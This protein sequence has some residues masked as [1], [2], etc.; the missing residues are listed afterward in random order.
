MTEPQPETPSAPNATGIRDL[1]TGSIPRHLIAFFWPMLAGNLL[2]SAHSLINAFWVGKFL[3][4]T[5][6]A[7]IMTSFPVVFV[8]IAVAG[9]L[10]MASNILVSQ[11]VGA[12]NLSQV[13]RVVQNSTILVIGLS[14]LFTILG[15]F[16]ALPLLRLTH[17]PPDVLPM[18]YDYLRVL[19]LTMPS[20]FAFFLFSSMLR[21]AGDSATP[22]RYMSISIILTVILDPIL[23]FG[24]LGLPRL[25][26]PGT[27]VANII[28]QFAAVIMLLMHLKRQGNIVMPQWQGLKLDWEISRQTFVLGGPSA[29]QQAIVSIGAVT[30]VGFI[31]RFGENAAAAFGAA[32]R[33]DQFAF[34]PAMSMGAAVA[35]LAGQNIGARRF[36]RVRQVFGWGV[37]ISCGLTL[38][39][40]LAAILIPGLL[41]RLFLN[42]T[43][44]I[45]IGVEYLRIIGVGYLFLAVYFTCIGVINGAGHTFIPTV[46]TVVGLWLI[47]I[48]L[49]ANLPAHVGGVRGIWYAMA[50]SFAVSMTLGL[51]Y[52]FSGYWRRAI[53]RTQS[54]PPPVPSPEPE[55]RGNIPLEPPPLDRIDPAD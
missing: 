18:A 1:T 21:G 42:D 51:I 15:E 31:N 50:I 5:A 7:A 47:R 33:I 30:M 49:A 43:Q 17:T 41:L 40:T 55:S 22:V 32:M 38:I 25:G 46:I 10:T 48:P 4:T 53:I 9:G 16:V 8:L 12:G 13:R 28:A 36:G 11:Y 39:V 27:A 34:L 6:M 20:A 37:L 26:L 24:W 23:M 35:S 14:I 54:A 2:Q 19:M 45:A 44:V 3:G 52:Y 29:L